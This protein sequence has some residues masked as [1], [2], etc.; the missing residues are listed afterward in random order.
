MELPE[1]GKSQMLLLQECYSFLAL[2]SSNIYSHP[3]IIHHGRNQ[4]LSAKGVSAVL[5]AKTTPSLQS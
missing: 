5:I 3:I 4:T 2:T 1:L